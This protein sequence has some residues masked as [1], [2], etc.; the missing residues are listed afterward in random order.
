MGC[1]NA[2]ADALFQQEGGRD[3]R[4]QLIQQDCAAIKE[5][6]IVTLIFVPPYV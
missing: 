4:G 3:V 6:F 5:L 2:N 1:E